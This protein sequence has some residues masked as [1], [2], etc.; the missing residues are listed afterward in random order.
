ML[1]K[2][3]AQ[4][5]NAMM[6]DGLAEKEIVAVLKDGSTVSIAQLKASFGVKVYEPTQAEAETLPL[7]VVG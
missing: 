4:G 5:L 7:L 1:V 3:L 6:S 2:E